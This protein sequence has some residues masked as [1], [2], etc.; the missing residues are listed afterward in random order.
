MHSFRRHWY[1]SLNIA[2]VWMKRKKKLKPEKRCKVR[3]QNSSIKEPFISLIVINILYMGIFYGHRRA[4]STFLAPMALIR[5]ERFSSFRQRGMD[6]WCRDTH[7]PDPTSGQQLPGHHFC[8]QELE[9]AGT[10]RKLR[11][12]D[13][14]LARTELAREPGSHC[15]ELLWE[16]ADPLQSFTDSPFVRDRASTASVPSRTLS[17]PPC[18]FI[19]QTFPVYT[20]YK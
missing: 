6:W 11:T 8:P 7:M 9:G 5:Q 19:S 2:S 10:C 4:L 20:T 3:T 17:V 12:P 1:F 18:M 14:T 16:M 15:Q 13:A